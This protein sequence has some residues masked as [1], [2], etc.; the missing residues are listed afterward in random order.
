MP[1]EERTLELLPSLR[2]DETKFIPV[3]PANVKLMPIY[4]VNRYYFTMAGRMKVVWR[5]WIRKWIRKWK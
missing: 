1:L 4:I 5:E 3:P 2:L